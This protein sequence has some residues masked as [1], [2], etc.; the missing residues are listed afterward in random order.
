MNK[1]KLFFLIVVGIIILAVGFIAFVELFK[2]GVLYGILGIVISAGV[3][4][5][6]LIWAIIK[7]MK[8]IGR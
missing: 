1:F 8:K 5:L 2:A 7:D 3:G 4:L 6:I